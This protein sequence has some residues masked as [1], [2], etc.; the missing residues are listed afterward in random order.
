MELPKLPDTHDGTKLWDWLAFFK[1][2]DE[3]QLRSLANQNQEVAKVV[4]AYKNMTVEEI[5]Q[6]KEWESDRAARNKAQFIAD[7]KRKA[8]A[9]GMAK[10]LAEGKNEVAVRLLRM[11]AS[12]A[13][14]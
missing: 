5:E 1:S 4:S 3:S 7:E 2:K 6:I 11:S 8:A 10:G 9:E 13:G 14:C 12:Q